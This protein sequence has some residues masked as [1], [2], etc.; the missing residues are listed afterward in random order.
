MAGTYVFSA[1]AMILGLL[2]HAADCLLQRHRRQPKVID[3]LSVFQS[4]PVPHIDR[5]AV[6]IQTAK[7]EV[8]ATVA[9]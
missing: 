3:F 6:R 2:L 9:L 8:A 7:N 4:D 5:C 1:L